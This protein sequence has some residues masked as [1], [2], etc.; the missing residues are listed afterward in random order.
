MYGE[1]GYMNMF[2]GGGMFIWFIICLGTL[3][4]LVSL[5]KNKEERVKDTSALDTLKL[6]YAKGDISKESLST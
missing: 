6:R 4:F 5:F 2:H 1:F 3:V